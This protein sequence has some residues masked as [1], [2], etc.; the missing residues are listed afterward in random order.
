[1][2]W[3]APT[4]AIA[5]QVYVS[6][7]PVWMFSVRSSV[8]PSVASPGGRH[9]PSHHITDE[10]TDAD[11]PD[12]AAEVASPGIRRGQDRIQPCDSR[13]ISTRAPPERTPCFSLLPSLGLVAAVARR[14]GGQRDGGGH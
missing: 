5:C 11:E 13:T 2:G 12:D 6:C 4:C 7:C 10:E 8:T 3:A 14:R 9:R 1:M